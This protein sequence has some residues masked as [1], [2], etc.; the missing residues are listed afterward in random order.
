MAL[1]L[2]GTGVAL[3][4]PFRK[5]KSIDFKSMGKLVEHVISN[6][7]DYLVV[8]G[9]T[10]EASTLSFEE[11]KAVV[12][13]VVEQ[14]NKRVPVI[15]GLGGNNTQDILQRLN[16][17]EFDGVDAILSVVPYY[18]KP[19]QK[20][21]FDH[22]QMISVE[23]PVPVILYNVPA[24]TSCNLAAETTVKLAQEC[25][26]IVAVK[27]ASGNF[28][29]VMHILR[30]K[31]K[32]FTV[33]SGDDAIAL[34][35]ISLGAK[36]VISVTANA[37]PKEYSS[38]VRFALNDDFC[39]SRTLQMHLLDFYTALFAEGSPAG[40]KTALSIMDITG[41]TVR[42]PL[43]QVSSQLQKRMAQ[44]IEDIRKVQV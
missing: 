31:P 35:L 12:S 18:N 30:D 43:S 34:P 7:V 6:G 19:T 20:G 26:N 27:E 39:K 25:K 10:G 28:D 9:T 5:D 40:L 29:Q 4:T 44:I 38:M 32:D 15:A 16:N 42:P 21:L 22:F 17:F 13:F 24:R 37:F 41:S 3:A 33:L 11:K 14:A 23:S 8:L 1:N 2:N 36:G